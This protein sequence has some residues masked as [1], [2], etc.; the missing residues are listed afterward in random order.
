MRVRI[1]DKFGYEFDVTKIHESTRLREGHVDA[2]PPLLH[3]VSPPGAG[4]KES[5][6]PVLGI[7]R[8]FGLGNARRLARIFVL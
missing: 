5:A 3:V 7:R 4:R 1:E 2:P 8:H 6:S